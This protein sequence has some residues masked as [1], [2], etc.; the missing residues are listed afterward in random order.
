MMSCNDSMLKTNST[1]FFPFLFEAL[2]SIVQG[3]KTCTVISSVQ[4]EKLQSLD[5]YTKL[6]H[7]EHKNNLHSK[8]YILAGSTEGKSYLGQ[9]ERHESSMSGLFFDLNNF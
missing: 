4:T 9:G 6:T 3:R 2:P 8:L 7:S 1:F 5:S